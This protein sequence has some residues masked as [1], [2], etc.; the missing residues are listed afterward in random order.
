MTTFI[1][2][3]PALGSTHPPIQWVSGALSPGVKWSG[4]ETDHSHVVPRLMMRGAIPP[5]LQYFFIE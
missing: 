3:R 5:L 2:G 4:R 1:Y